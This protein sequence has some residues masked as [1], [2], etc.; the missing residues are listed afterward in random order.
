MVKVVAASQNRTMMG[1]GEREE[2]VIK[3][4]LA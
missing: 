3:E 4:S 2:D 1:V